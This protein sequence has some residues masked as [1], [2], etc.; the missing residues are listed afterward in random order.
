MSDTICTYMAGGWDNVCG[1]GLGRTTSKTY[2]NAI[3]N[4]LFLDMEAKLANR[5][6]GSTSAS[7]LLGGQSKAAT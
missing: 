3:P 6:A 2:K 5:T 4:E 1:G 7:Y